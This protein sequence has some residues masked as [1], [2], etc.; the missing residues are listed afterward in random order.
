MRLN[1]LELHMV[2]FGFGESKYSFRFRILVSVSRNNLYNPAIRLTA[3]P[4]GVIIT[5]TR[6]HREPEDG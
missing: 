6:Q 5:P 1:T 4:V 3:K 2:S